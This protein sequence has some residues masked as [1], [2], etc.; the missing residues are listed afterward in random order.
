M[1]DY[2]D[3]LEEWR[4][5]ARRKA[6]ELDEKYSI[7]ERVEEGARAAGEAARRGAE[8]AEK[9]AERARAEAERF[10]D[11]FD[12]GERA[13]EVREHTKEAREKAS[14]ARSE[15]TRA[16]RETGARVRE[17]AVRAG[18]KAGEAF[19]EAKRY[20]ARAARVADVGAR[21][22]RL[23]GASTVGLFR[24]YDWARENPKQAIVVTLSLAVGVRAGAALPGLDAVFLGSHP[25]WF[26]HSALPVYA[27]R[28]AGEKFDGYLRERE[29]LLEEGELETAERER[30][31]FERKIVRYVGAPLLGAFSCAAGVAMWAQILQP[32]TV[33]GAPLEWLIGGNPLLSGVWL[34]SNGVVCFHQGYKFFMIALKDQEDAER[35]VREIKGLLPATA[36]A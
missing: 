33:V 9:V 20:Y 1:A 32:G 11:D 29:R 21:A 13:E 24:V 6:R 34:F 36:T 23:T 22:T 2:T 35:I 18:E 7:R 19:G 15:A 27:L 12:L 30:V 10:G 17:K 31:E 8:K 4:E 3:K 16:A 26:T 25:H 14:R 5:A 28:K